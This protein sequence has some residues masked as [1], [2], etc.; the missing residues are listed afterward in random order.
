MGTNR[1]KYNDTYV[2]TKY[3]FL[4]NTYNLVEQIKLK[5]MTII[6]IFTNSDEY[7]QEYPGKRFLAQTPGLISLILLW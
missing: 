1:I 7:G 6:K 4:Y 5:G 3:S 2:F